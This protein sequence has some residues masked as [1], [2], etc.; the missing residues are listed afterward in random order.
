MTDNRVTFEGAY[1]ET[2]YQSDQTITFV[3]A[4]VE[5]TG[6]AYG[7]DNSQTATSVTAHVELDGGDSQVATAVN[8]YIEQDG[9]DY[10]GAT[11]VS[12]YIETK[13]SGLDATSVAAYVELEDGNNISATNVSAYV[14]YAAIATDY[15]SATSVTAYVELPTELSEVLVSKVV[16]LLGTQD[17]GASV[18][19]LATYVEY[20]QSDLYLTKFGVLVEVDEV[21]VGMPTY[22][23]NKTAGPQQL[24]KLPDAVT[25]YAL[26]PEHSFWSI[27]VPE[28]TT[29]FCANPSFEADSI[30]SHSFS[31]WSVNPALSTSWPYASRGI[32][33]AVLTPLASTQGNFW[34]TWSYTEG[35]WTF[36]CDVFGSPGEKFRLEIRLGTST[37]MASNTFTIQEYKWNRYHVTATL[38]GS[39]T[40]SVW[41]ISTDINTGK[42]LYT[43]GWQIE[44][45]A[46]P[47]TYADGNMIGNRDTPPVRSYFWQGAPNN[48][49]SQRTADDTLAGRVINFSEEIGFLTTAIVGLGLPEGNIREKQVGSIRRTIH[50][51]V[52]DKPRTFTI[53][54]RIMKCAL[55][56]L[57][58]KRAYLENLLR[59]DNTVNRDQVKLRFRLTD[60]DGEFYGKALEIP[61]VYKSGM[62]G[63]ITNFYQESIAI[64]MRAAEPKLSEIWDNNQE[65]T[66]NSE[67]TDNKVFY[68]DSTGHW[69]RL[70]TGSTNDVV[71]G[72]AIAIN[73]QVT[74]SSSAIPMV[75]GRFTQLCGVAIN[76]AGYWDG[77]TWQQIGNFNNNVIELRS[78]FSPDNR[79]YLGGDFT[80]NAAVTCARIAVWTSSGIT[81]CADGLDD[82]VYDIKIGPDGWAYISGKFVQDRPGV[83]TFNY[84]A[85]Y[86][87]DT[88]MMYPVDAANPGLNSYVYNMVI[89]P[90]NWLWITGPFTQNAAGDT[91][92]GYARMN[93]SLPY[94][95][96]VFE[97]IPNT[98]GSSGVVLHTLGVGPDG[99]VYTTRWNPSDGE[100][101]FMRFN[102]NSWEQV[103]TYGTAVPTNLPYNWFGPDG[104]GYVSGADMEVPFVNKYVYSLTNVS[105][106]GPV[107]WAFDQGS[108]AWVNTMRFG[109]DSSI[110]IASTDQSA[111]PTITGTATTLVVNDGSAAV[112]PTIRIQGPATLHCIINRTTGAEIWFNHGDEF[113]AYVSEEEVLFIDLST[114]R[115]RIYSD[116][117]R[118]VPNILYS[119]STSTQKFWLQPGE[120][121]ISILLRNTTASTK[122]HLL[123]KN[124]HWAIDYS[125]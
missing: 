124:K 32:Q 46:Y 4:Y 12:A 76:Y 103:G 39:G 94:D 29:N 17:S 36:S 113:N 68:R 22:L 40:A 59:Y 57:L 107:E 47:T 75:C 77:S 96:R 43:D 56:V 104:K 58:E 28:E 61:V 90:D 71:T 10:V 120:N 118:S 125:V 98:T 54:G 41:L 81:E 106:L 6:S 26:D 9:G 115:T 89:T 44:P 79:V 72:G 62:A 119:P 25:G 35:Q 88:D 53:T 69:Q 52:F 7:T 21:Y 37:V 121:H 64:Q 13:Q 18:S 85:Q 117:R 83:K 122:A 105:Q 14:E 97:A 3:G 23:R 74:T 15:V 63:N 24:Q 84:F 99:S 92:T 55:D 16:A 38:S 11:N 19:Q 48:S 114:G 87:P 51:T 109:K 80:T 31:S 45:K 108:S 50:D 116:Q 102:G 2:D 65:L 1:V 27:I 70:G 95:Q 93:L 66:I 5:T 111:S 110:I 91:L 82:T 86:D 20:T 100:E 67:Y 33:F 78:A 101:Q 73:P 112:Y 123:W 34:Y 42:L 60:N 49:P 30:L 8:A